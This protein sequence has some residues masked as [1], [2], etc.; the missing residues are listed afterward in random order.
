M[1][2]WD[3]LNKLFNQTGVKLTF[4]L[5][6]LIGKHKC[7]D[8]DLWLGNWCPKNA[9]DLIN[10]TMFQEH[11]IDSYE[12]GDE[13]CLS[14]VFAVQSKYY[15][16]EKKKKVNELPPDP[17]TRTAV[18]GPT[19]FMM[20]NSLIPFSQATGPNVVQGVTHRIYNLGAGVEKTLTDKVTICQKCG[21]RGWTELLIFC[22]ACQA[23][24]VHRY[25]LDVL[26]A[27]FD[28]YAEWLCEDCE[29]KVATSSFLDKLS[30][31]Q[32]SENDTESFESVKVKKRNH[33]NKLKKKSK[34]K[35]KS[36]SKS[37]VLERRKT[38]FLHLNEVLCSKNSEKDQEFARQN[39]MDEC[40]LDEAVESLK[41]KNCRP[42]VVDLQLLEMNCCKDGK[43]DEKHGRK[44]DFNESSFHEEAECL[45]I[46]NSSVTIPLEV[47][48]PE[49]GEIEQKI[50][51]WNGLGE[52]CFSGEAER[53]N[54][55]GSSCEVAEPC[56]TNNSQ[57]VVSYIP[58]IV[59]H[60]Q[61]IKDPIW[62][63]SLS[64][65]EKKFGTVVG[66]VAHVSSIACPKASE[67]AK[68]LPTLLSPELLPRAAVWPKGF[69]KSGPNDDSI[70][71][72]FFP[73]S[74]RNEKVFD[75][76]VNEMISQELAMRVDVQNAELLIFTSRILPMEFWRFQAKF[77][78]WGV[79]KG[80]RT[81]KAAVDD[82]PG[83][84]K[85]LTKDLTWDRRSPLSTSGSA[86]YPH[87]NVGRVEQCGATTFRGKLVSIVYF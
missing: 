23:Y 59:V 3:Q 80:K 7:N 38:S 31:F 9:S 8:S 1:D 11:K 68:S 48:Y 20:S 41:R 70:A 43:K 5:S 32:V 13:L 57:L 67:E 54:G 10:Y 22:R 83:E 63:G 12:L 74:E 50:E 72:Y 17:E 62:R 60:A 79:F 34:R 15:L 56:R 39:G 25:C 18:L 6:A 58:N 45:K 33:V 29:P 2:R 21:D 35:V 78:L 16:I 81:S 46:N 85:G 66:L 75:S 37:R 69:E 65:L 76:L 84:G 64:L 49:P 51:R 19:G 52:D 55:L 71:L 86:S 28:E 61:P 47:N 4:G 42:N 73:D 24:A 30:P 14:G 82:N 87:H 77:Y 36:C 40:G 44:H 53:P 27:T 26:P